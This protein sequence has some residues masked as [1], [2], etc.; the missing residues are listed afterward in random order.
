MDPLLDRTGIP[1]QYLIQL[2]GTV[3]NETFSGAQVLLTLNAAN[4]SSKYN[5][6]YLIIIEGFPKRNSD[7]SF[8]WDSEDSEMAATANEITCDIKRTFVKKGN[9]FFSFL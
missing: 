6:P 9:I 7:N 8:F 3:M 2:S 5:N 4:P 1:K